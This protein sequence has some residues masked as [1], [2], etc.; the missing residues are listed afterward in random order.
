MAST[1]DATSHT[2]LTP[3]QIRLRL[4]PLYGPCVLCE[5]RCGAMRADGERGECGLD[6]RVH[7]YN[8]LLH[9]GEEAPLVP[10]YTV[11]LSA[12]N[13]MC[14]FCSE[15]EHLTPPFQP[16]ATDPEKLAVKA[17][18][19]LERYRAR[20]GRVRN[21]NF[22]GGEPS[23]ALPFMARFA[24]ALDARVERRPPLLLNSNGYMTPEALAL[25]THLCPV[26]VIDLKFGPGGCAESV[27][28]VMDYWRVLTRNLG[29]LHQAIERPDEPPVVDGVAVLPVQ[30]WVR[31]LLM[32]NHLACCTAPCL[33]WL[34]QQAPQARV[35]VMPAFYPFKGEGNDP[36]PHLKD[37]ERS[38]GRELLQRSG[39]VNAW[40]DGRRFKP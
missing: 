12:C 21:I 22:V 1:T 34:S 25:A 14:S 38:E 15:W 16:A 6:H 11:F 29:L 35:N 13:F 27:A 33:E 32:P 30:L 3:G 2:R 7:V 9:M 8:R 17:A 23:I 4:E 39:V 20:V 5:L 28:G 10:S 36:W 24:E 19:E 18:A 37:E 26:M 40:F 31:H